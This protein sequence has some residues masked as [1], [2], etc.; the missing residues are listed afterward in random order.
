MSEGEAA[1]GEGEREQGEA[2]AG[3]ADGDEEERVYVSLQQVVRQSRLGVRDSA[4]Q[5]VLF[6]ECL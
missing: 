2:E 6:A 1:D 3:G 5:C 4:E